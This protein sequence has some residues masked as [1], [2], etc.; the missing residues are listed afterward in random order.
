[1]KESKMKNELLIRCEAVLGEVIKQT[2]KLDDADFPISIFVDV[3]ILYNEL[4][5]ENHKG[6]MK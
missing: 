1:M 4:E 2:R 3:C 5:R 6:E